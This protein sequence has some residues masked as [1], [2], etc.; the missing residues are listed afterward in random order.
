MLNGMLSILPSG[1]VAQSMPPLEK[2]LSWNA[3]S[4]SDLSAT[5]GRTSTSQL[6]LPN[7]RPCT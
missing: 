5:S 1:W 2:L 7:S 6:L 4:V 3:G